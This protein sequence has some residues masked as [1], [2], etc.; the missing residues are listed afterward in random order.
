MTMRKQTCS[1]TN[2]HTVPTLPDQT[3][4]CILTCRIHATSLTGSSLAFLEVSTGTMVSS[5]LEFCVS[6]SCSTN[7]EKTG[8][9]DMKVVTYRYRHSQQAVNLN[10]RKLAC[11]CLSGS[12]P[13]IKTLV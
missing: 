4:L 1:V 2:R 10:I 3:R 11:A 8:E 7:R 5:S 12:R 13:P 9:A 6:E